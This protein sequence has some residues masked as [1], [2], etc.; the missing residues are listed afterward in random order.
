MIEYSLYRNSIFY[1]RSEGFPQYVHLYWHLLNLYPFDIGILNKFKIEK[2][3]ERARPISLSGISTLRLSSSHEFIYLCMHAF[4]HAFTPFVLLCDLKIILSQE[5][6]DFDWDD[7]VTE[8]SSLG[9]SKY[10][11]YSLCLVAELFN[12]SVPKDI[13]ARL[14]PKRQSIFEKRLLD[15]VLKREVPGFFS[16][17]GLVS[18]GMNES[19]RDRLFYLAGAI[20]PSKKDMALI[21]QKDISKVGASDYIKRLF[22]SL[23]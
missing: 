7:L 21:H 6:E 19:L 12:L 8:S 11:Y 16:G 9:L 15:S 2:I 3:W 4:K 23:S 5:N 13:L 17:V 10:V 14:K 20:F 1:T 22:S 18:F